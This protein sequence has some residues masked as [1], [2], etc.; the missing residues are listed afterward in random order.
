MH[1]SRTM[2]GRPPVATPDA[3]RDRWAQHAR[4]LAF[5]GASWPNRPGAHNLVRAPS[6]PTAAYVSEGRWVADCP[7]CAG[8]VSVW[9]AMT[10]A[11]CYDCGRVL[12]VTFPSADDVL[13]AELLLSARAERKQNWRPDQGETVADL[14]AENA[15][16]MT[17][18]ERRQP[19]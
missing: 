19:R 3:V 6:R 9:L 15:R 18:R 5:G 1:D 16:C 13:V 17:R 2:H 8:G 7:W 4:S 10:D 12:P 11:C 14:Q